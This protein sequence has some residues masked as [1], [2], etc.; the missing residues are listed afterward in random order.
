[1]YVKCT[2]P[3]KH[4]KTA[5]SYRAQ[6]PRGSTARLTHRPSPALPDCPGQGGPPPTPLGVRPEVS[7]GPCGSGAVTGLLL[8]PP[9]RLWC[10]GVSC[11]MSFVSFL[12]S[13]RLVAAQGWGGR[14][15]GGSCLPL[16][17]LRQRGSAHPRV[18]C[19][20]AGPPG[21]RRRGFVSDPPAPAQPRAGA[22]RRAAG[23]DAVHLTCGQQQGGRD[24]AVAGEGVAR[25]QRL[26]LNVGPCL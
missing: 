6:L 23:L 3:P 4:C 17:F 20:Q 8:G 11:R 22:A 2:D 18:C 9:G 7:T 25:C 19:A 10:C 1:M 16:P 14:E 15:N 5:F 21:G 13:P 26:C 24:G 12:P